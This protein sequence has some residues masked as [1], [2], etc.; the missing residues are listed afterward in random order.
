V[1][2][3]IPRATPSQ[4]DKFRTL[5]SVKGN[6]FETQQTLSLWMHLASHFSSS[7]VTL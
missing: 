1:F 6:R 5:T 7:P 3:G 2:H 4:V